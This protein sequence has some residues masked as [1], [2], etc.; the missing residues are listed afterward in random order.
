[1]DGLGAYRVSLVAEV[2][3]A[4]HG[5]RLQVA[6]IHSAR[7]A[8]I[9]RRCTGR[10]H[11]RAIARHRVSICC[12]GGEPIGAGR[13]AVFSQ[14]VHLQLQLLLTF[15]QQWTLLAGEQ[16]VSSTAALRHLRGA[17]I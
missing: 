17:L 4:L 6:R 5:E 16:V 13:L 14:Q 2:Q 12:V 8:Q 3:A 1:M 9:L 10:V 15:L 7:D 11:P